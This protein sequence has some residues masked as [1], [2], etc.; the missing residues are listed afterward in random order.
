VRSQHNDLP[1]N[2]VRSGLLVDLVTDVRVD[3]SPPPPLVQVLGPLPIGRSG[4]PFPS[5]QSFV[6]GD[7]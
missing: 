4:P 7:P 3:P 6:P 5:I 1:L 2:L